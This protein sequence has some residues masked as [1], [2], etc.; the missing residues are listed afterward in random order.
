[1][2]VALS[3]KYYG[4]AI[5]EDQKDGPELCNMT[6]ETA[7]RHKLHFK[8]VYEWSDVLGHHI[9][10]N[11]TSS[12]ATFFAMAGNRR[13]MPSD[14][15]IRRDFDNMPIERKT[16]EAGQGIKSIL[17]GIYIFLIALDPERYLEAHNSV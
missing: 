11:P 5:R 8:L 10:A 6:L 13:T 4:V 7:G 17:K 12:I 2:A 1:M 16:A 14:K 3:R 15:H 9:S